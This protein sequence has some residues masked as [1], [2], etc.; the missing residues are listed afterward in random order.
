MDYLEKE[1]LKKLDLFVEFVQQNNQDLY[2]D[3]CK[4]V[5]QEADNII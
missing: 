5:D 4:Y 3:A 2:N 1:K